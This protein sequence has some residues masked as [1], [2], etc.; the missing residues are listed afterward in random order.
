MST[1]GAS[2]KVIPK[3]SRPG[4]IQ[5]LIRGGRSVVQ[6]AAQHR[7]TRAPLHPDEAPNALPV[8]WVS[9]QGG[10]SASRSSSSAGSAPPLPG[11]WRWAAGRGGG[12]GPRACR[13]FRDRDR[14]A[15]RTRRPPY[16][17]GRLA[18]RDPPPPRLIVRSYPVY[19]VHGPPPRSY[20]ACT[21]VDVVPSRGIIRFLCTGH[22]DLEA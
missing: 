7:L 11:C 14:P 21:Q 20:G 22:G 13:P 9:S 4:S 3:V 2:G 10:R 17:L 8:S 5:E 15:A 1:S 6:G 19:M 18:Y 16:D 12:P